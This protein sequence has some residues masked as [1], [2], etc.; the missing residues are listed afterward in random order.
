M[1]LSDIYSILIADSTF[2][3][4]VFGSVTPVAGLTD[5]EVWLL[6]NF[7]AVCYDGI[8]SFAKIFF[9]INV[10][11]GELLK[12]YWVIIIEKQK[13]IIPKMTIV[14]ILIYV[15]H[16]SVLG[17]APS[18]QCGWNKIMV[19]KIS[20]NTRACRI[21]THVKQEEIWFKMTQ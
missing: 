6:R 3:G 7:Y 10:V 11:Q 2:W 4:I 17:C 15:L 9:F 14:N 13:G 18:W 12:K 16:I 20:A 21:M 8:L 1:Y 19:V 5:C